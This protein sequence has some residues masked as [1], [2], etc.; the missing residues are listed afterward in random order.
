MNR[1][2]RTEEKENESSELPP[3]VITIRNYMLRLLGRRDHTVAELIRKAA[4][5]GYTTAS[6]QESVDE[7][8]AEGLLDD[9]R[10]AINY[11]EEK[12]R[13]KRWGP[14]KIRAG[15]LKKGVQ[16]EIANSALREIED[17][18]ELIQNCVDLVE[19]RRQHFYR[20]S[21]HFKRKQK[22]V[23]WLRQKG[24]RSDTIRKALPQIA[25]ML[26]V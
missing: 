24:Y 25:E 16:P 20:E 8:T 5:K 10:F 9:A 21:D 1:K 17:G 4:R 11:A 15:L 13:T 18:L 19:R 7:L 14:K 22:I 26:N 2:G 23:A 3:P 6:C 12:S